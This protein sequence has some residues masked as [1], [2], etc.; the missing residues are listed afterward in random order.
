M[1]EKDNNIILVSCS[2]D[3]PSLSPELRDIT[4]LLVVSAGGQGYPDRIWVQSKECAKFAI[5]PCKC[6]FQGNWIIPVPICHSVITW[7]AKQENIVGENYF[8]NQSAKEAYRSYVLSY[9]SHSMKDIF[10]VHQ[11]DLQVNVLQSFQPL[12]SWYYLKFSLFL[13]TKLAE[14][15]DITCPLV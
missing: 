14:N 13:A 9:D 8:L 3:L 15:T 6:P 4:H 1:C 2:P 12:H 11:L 5:T 10:N 7:V